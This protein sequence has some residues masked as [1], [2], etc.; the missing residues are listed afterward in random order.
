MFARF[1]GVAIIA[2]AAG[3]LSAGAQNARD[4][5]VPAELPPDSFTGQQ[6]VDSTGCAFIRAGFSG[7][8][9][10]VPRFDQDRNP[11]CGLPPSIPPAPPT[12]VAVAPEPEP[13]APAPALEAP[14]AAPRSAVAASPV[15]ATPPAAAQVD[16]TG[17]PATHC[18]NYDD[19]GQ[20]HTRGTPER[21][22]RCGPQPRHPVDGLRTVGPGEQVW[23][24]AARARPIPEGYRPAWRDDRLNPYR[25]QG[26][27]AGEA[28]MRQIWT[29]TVPRQLVDPGGPAAVPYTSAQAPAA[30][31]YGAR[32]S[33]RGT[34]APP[35]SEARQTPP[36]AAG[37]RFVQIGSFGVP[38]NAQ[39]AAGRFQSM[40]LPVRLAEIRSGGQTLQVV[41]VGPFAA[42]ADLDAALRAARQ[43]GFSDAFVRG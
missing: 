43:A 3:A 19:I 17:G 34:I 42:Q 18:S 40:G 29:D 10:W 30:P 21:P 22:V 12:A 41:L 2:T 9:N 27:A 6:Y 36:V 8:V 26:T 23:Q 14:A 37:N 31:D 38:A 39:A 13:P 1:L 16:V 24:P 20:A 4:P 5:Y 32:V 11:V 7:Q 35:A 28:Q 25:G 15:P 33:T